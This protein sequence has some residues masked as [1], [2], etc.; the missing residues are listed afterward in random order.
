MGKIKKICLSALLLAGI[1]LAS[2]CY[3]PDDF[4]GDVTIDKNGDFI[5]DYS[6]ILTWAPF[7][8][9]IKE[10]KLAGEEKEKKIAAAEADLA[11]DTNFTEIESLGDA[12]FRVKY[13]RE[14]KIKPNS[15]I[16]FVRRDSFIMKIKADKTA[17]TATFSG[18]WMTPEKAEQLV[19]YG[20]KVQGIFRVRTDAEV[21][22]SN[23]SEVIKLKNGFTLYYWKVEGFSNT[24]PSLVVR[25]NP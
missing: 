21:I 18:R 5:I 23:A 15:L 24:P 10:G 4:T 12:Q 9:Q 1:A 11:R 14:G 2:A 17:S 13:H 25:L 16:T 8:G 3:V 6:G 20:L 22:S 7:Y 19:K